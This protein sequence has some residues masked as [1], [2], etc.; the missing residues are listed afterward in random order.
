MREIGEGMKRIFAATHDSGQRPPTLYSNTT[1][2][3]ITLYKK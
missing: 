1:W 3:T 2:F